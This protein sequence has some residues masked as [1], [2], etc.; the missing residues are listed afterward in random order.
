MLARV[1]LRFCFSVIEGVRYVSVP[2]EQK[3]IGTSLANLAKES[4]LIPITP[5]IFANC[6]CLTVLVSGRTDET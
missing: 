2:G 4:T 1:D 3:E 6:R 5:G